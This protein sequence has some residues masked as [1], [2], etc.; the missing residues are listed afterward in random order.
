[1]NSMDFLIGL[2][3]GLLFGGITGVL[4]VALCAASSA[5]ETNGEEKRE[6]DEN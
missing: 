1:M 3:A 5:N 2:I 4:A 6:N